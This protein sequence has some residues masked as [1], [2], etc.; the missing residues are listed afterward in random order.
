MPFKDSFQL[1]GDNEDIWRDHYQKELELLKQIKS[2]EQSDLADV[3]TR[4]LRK[5]AYY[6]ELG[7]DFVPAVPSA[8]EEL[9][10]LI[11]SKLGASDEAQAIVSGVNLAQ[12]D[13]ED[14]DGNDPTEEQYACAPEPTERR[15]KRKRPFAEETDWVNNDSGTELAAS[16]DEY[17]PK[18]RRKRKKN[19]NKNKK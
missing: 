2:R 19:K 14:E 11:A 13:S 7:M 9:L 6:F 1:H 18:P 4:A 15:S 8:R 12:S 16:G 5:F 3:C 10:Q 17:D